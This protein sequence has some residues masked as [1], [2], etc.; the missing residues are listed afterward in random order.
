[1]PEH[2]SRIKRTARFGCVVLL[3]MLACLGACAAL[4]PGFPALQNFIE[5]NRIRFEVGAA[6]GLWESHQIADYDIDLEGDAFSQCFI[7]YTSHATLHVRDGK[8]ITA[9]VLSNR[10]ITDTANWLRVCKYDDYLPTQMLNGIERAVNTRDPARSYLHISFDPEYGF[11]TNYQSGCYLESDCD[12]TLK[13]SNFQP[14]QV[15]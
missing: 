8:L 15:K 13:F 14:I 3:V 9:T 2:N 6:K 5:L 10:I 7:Q 4:L 11:V 1:M 12:V